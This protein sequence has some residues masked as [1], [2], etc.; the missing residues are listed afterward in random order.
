MSG[1]TT[2]FE[3]TYYDVEGYD[4]QNAV[5]TDVA[6]EIASKSTMSRTW[7]FATDEDGYCDYTE[8]YKVSGDELFYKGDY[9]TLPLGT[10][11]IR[12]VA[13]PSGYL[14][15]HYDEN[16]NYID[17]TDIC[18]VR[19]VTAEGNRET[20]DTYNAPTEDTGIKEQD[21]DLVILS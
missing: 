2:T 7:T 11:V 12:E 14:N 3:T 4:N 17:H 15:G 21:T 16:N 13:A 19:S 8:K 9:P 18:W 1:Q 10:V 20:V 5:N 6:A